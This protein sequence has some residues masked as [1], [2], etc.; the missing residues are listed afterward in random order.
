MNDQVNV[1]N[2]Q[3][4]TSGAVSR[5]QK[6]S[7][8]RVEEPVVS[9]NIP[10]IPNPNSATKRSRGPSA[11]SIADSTSPQPEPTAPPV[12][13]NSRRSLAKRSTRIEPR[14]I[15]IENPEPEEVVESAP[16]SPVLTQAISFNDAVNQTNSN[17][18]SAYVSIIQQLIHNNHVNKLPKFGGEP[19]EDF[20]SWFEEFQTATEKRGLSESEQISLLKTKLKGNARAVLDGLQA[21][22]IDTLSRIR[23]EMLKT[24]APLEEPS[25]LRLRLHEIRRKE[26][27]NIRVFARSLH[28]KVVRAFPM[29]ESNAAETLTVAFFIQAVGA[30]LGNKISSRK[31]GTLDQAI[32]MAVRYDS[33]TNTK[34]SKKI[35]AP[36]KSHLQILAEEP[37]ADESL[38]VTN[39][40]QPS[41]AIPKRNGGTQPI[42][43]CSLMEQIRNNNKQTCQQISE[44][45]KQIQ[46]EKKES[47]DL[48]SKTPSNMNPSQIP[49]TSVYPNQHSFPTFRPYMNPRFQKNNFRG[50]VAR[51]NPY[52]RGGG[53]PI[54]QH[55]NNDNF[56]F[57]SVGHQQKCWTCNTPGHMARNCPTKQTQ[58]PNLNS[59]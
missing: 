45:R 22:K 16:A 5:I 2:L 43:L 9:N 14:P 34:I 1:N 52:T 23:L 19:E 44:L 35:N 10:A 3:P 51:F 33:E 38:S 28:G 30:E 11:P 37:N 53:A 29:M 50:R 17:E 12:L 20:K 15:A 26:G 32:D 56:K 31:P 36:P 25:E 42:T 6:R 13:R 24:F 57:R 8:R 47:N 18:S 41:D 49:T 39:D 4:V 46:N 59:K 21:N 48:T 40:P 27:E 7:A 54:G 58:N 55:S